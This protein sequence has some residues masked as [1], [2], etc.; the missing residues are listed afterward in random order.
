[1]RRPIRI[2]TLLQIGIFT[3]FTIHLFPQVNNIRVDYF[4]SDHGLSQNQ[5]LCLYKDS[6]GLLWIGTQDG[7]NLYDGY[8]FKVFRHEPGNE[9][10]LPDYAVNTVCETDTG[11][12]WIGT[13]AGM[14]KFDLQTG[15][16]THYVH[17][18]DSSN[19]LPDNYVWNII[20]DSEKKLWIGT[21][22]GLSNFNPETKTLRNFRKDQLGSGSIS[23]NFI[24]EIV[25][26]GYKNIWI[27]GRGGLDR[28]DLKK[29]KFFNYKLFPE[30]PDDIALNGIMSL[31]IKNE[32]LWIGSYSGLYSVKLK[33]YDEEEIFIEKHLLDSE[34]NQS[35][36]STNKHQQHSVR[37]IFV[38]SDNT[39]W[40]GT[41]GSGLIRFN[42]STGKINF[43]KS[44]SKV[45]SISEDYH[46][47]LL[48][49]MQGVLWIGTSSSGLNKFNRS[50]ERFKNLV[51][52]DPDGN[53]KSG[54]SSLIEDRFGNL[55]V[56]TLSG[57]IVKISN[58]F[59]DKQ[60]LRYFNTDKN[61]KTYFSP[62]EIRTFYED[63]NGN[64]WVGSF[65]KGI[66]VIDPVR[67]KV[68]RIV[69]D[70]NNSKSIASD[71]IHCIFESSDGTIWIGTGAGGLNKF[72]PGDN[73]FTHYKHDPKNEKS[74][75]TDEV[76][77]VCE[78]ENGFIWAGTSIGGL[79]KLD[80]N[81]G[82]F[83]RFTHKVKD[84]NSIAGNRIICLYL[85]RKNNLWIGTFG[86]GLNKWLPEEKSFQYY[87][88]DHG[89][90]SN[91]INH[92]TEDEIGNL[93]ISTDKGLSVFN[94]ELNTFKN[95]DVNDGLQGNEFIHG[96]GYVSKQNG[97]IFL[98]GINGLNMFNPADLKTRSK[99]SSI[100]FTDFKVFNK[101][102]LPGEE[103]PLKKNIFYAE[104]V[105]L[106][107]DENFFTF[108]FASLD[109]NNPHKNQYA[110]MM[111]GFNRD[112]IHAGNQRTATYTNLDPG[113]YV[114]RV[115]A[116]NSDGIWNE[117]GISIRVVLL[118]PWWQTW[119]AYLLYAVFLVSILYSLRQYEM[120]RVKLRNELQLKDFE[121]KKLK[122]VDELKSHFFANI[123][124]EF[125][126]PLT[127]ILGLLQ[128][129]ES[130]TADKKELED[131]GVMKRNAVKLLQLINQLLELSKI[132][133][134]KAKLAVSEDDIVTFVKRIFVSFA[135]Y[136]EQK[137]IKLQFNGKDINEITDER[138]NLFFD[139]DKME[140]II[141]NLVSNAVKYTPNG[142]E[143]EAKV[144]VQNN[145]A[146]IKVVN[147]G[148][149]ISKADLAHLFERYYKV[150]RAESGLFEGTGI[151]LALVKELVELHKGTIGVSS[152]YDVTEFVVKFPLGKDHLKTDEIIKHTKEEK[153]VEKFET[154]GGFEVLEEI[155][156]TTEDSVI[157]IEKDIILIV[158]DHSDLR[159]YI[160]DNLSDNYHVVESPNG[161]EGL[162][163]AIE[164][165]PD[166]I[167]SDVMM[168]EMD[169]YTFCKKVKTNETTNH[170]PVILLTAKAS[171][172]DKLEGL[173]LG[174]DDYLIKPF[175]P[176]ELKLRVKNLIKIREQLRQK[177][178]SEMVLKPTEVV[179]PSTQVRFM[180][181][182]KSTIENNLEDESFGVDKL[183]DEMGMSRS[184]LHRKLKAITNQSTTE[185]IR[186]F[187]LQRAAQLI[188]QDAGSMAEIAYNV[189]F[190]SQA[191]FNKSFQE[192]FGCSPSEYKKTQKPH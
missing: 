187:R 78:D 156:V 50:S 87:S 138:I 142:N 105:V 125:R 117:Q 42:P 33:D 11:I 164:V 38:G 110:Y 112:W 178:T 21:R 160:R 175:N 6:K 22:N 183:S 24:L 44:S 3:L 113:E 7:L 111:E 41:Y 180:E 134:G 171:T 172:E 83:E 35:E 70:R 148:V 101:S 122:E 51:I 179:V 115:K 166:L 184:Q 89:L 60:A 45:G 181:K 123:S 157:K 10:S 54:I 98:G 59:S 153:T 1:M 8:R 77:S 26:D 95:Y 146:E 63:K 170:I 132:E 163:K 129:F 165:I 48:E 127:L 185:F 62:I 65:G 106:S 120:K 56:G 168:P 43:Y 75:S 37:T 71:F 53:E 128:K 91:I 191:Y 23:H 81:T 126:T 159:K 68:S 4:N 92:I 104:E 90:P 124:H 144:F 154:R 9:N 16:F 46:V 55:W 79:N 190:N 66:Y 133:S 140:K 167:I 80:R 176:E 47:T 2:N 103:S 52:P 88:T 143:V 114:F 119:W 61:L 162:N 189:G 177:F 12:F 121:S 150:H 93:W 188:L 118:P 96:A 169:G 36:H 84:K 151:G 25:E 82:L 107:H 17:N 74:I 57:N 139:K 108:E 5:I 116:T 137:K 99:I 13:R 131:Y 94:V 72:N 18:P 86:G 20:E 15:K 40:A 32:V 135:S 173:G 192:L 31:F 69:N 100:V 64:I 102:V 14:S 73:S 97:N 28:Y 58:P 34:N 39:V 182:I 174:A 158:E 145:Q 147:T 161:K 29:Q 109:F 19:T 136:A 149:T 155:P 67:D 30:S 49:D 186:N 141:S 130:K 152:E 27:G 76:T 85:D